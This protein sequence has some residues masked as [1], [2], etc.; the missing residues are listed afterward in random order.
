LSKTDTIAALARISEAS[1]PWAALVAWLDER[2]RLNRATGGDDAT[3]IGT[4]LVQNAT[5]ALP[6]RSGGRQ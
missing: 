2:R 5:W 4:L 3:F 6:V 1:D